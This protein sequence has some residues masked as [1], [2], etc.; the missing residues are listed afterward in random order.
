VLQRLYR[1]WALSSRFDIGYM[2]VL[3]AAEIALGVLIIRKVAYTEIDW[4]AYMQEV[5]GYLGGERDYLKLRG[6]TGALR[7]SLHYLFPPAILT[8]MCCILVKYK[9]PLVYPA[10]FLYLFSLLR[11]WTEQGANIRTAQHIFLAMYVLTQGA[12]LLLYQTRI[13]S[14]RNNEGSVRMAEA[15]RIRHVWSWRV[16][17]AALCLSKR[18]HSIFLLRLFNDGPTMLLLYVSV[19]LFARNQWFAGCVLY[20]LAVSV[21]M[22]VLLFAPGL[23]LLLLQSSP[24]VWTLIW[25]LGAG[26]ALPQLV[27][28]A[29]FLLAHPVSY[30]RK[31]FELDR[32]FFY[33]WTVNWKVRTCKNASVCAFDQSHL[34]NHTLFGIPIRSFSPRTCSRPR[35][36]RSCF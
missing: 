30:L 29:P 16:A 33:Q 5:E 32:V 35:S 15:S 36:C 9:G 12:V 31:A 6:D 2:A 11:R 19:I 24:N 34:D 23:L 18:M 13:R 27:L 4:V 25:R 7:G 20:S 8:R 28:G 22:N 26:C 14:I 21:K 1:Q 17:M 10:G 3:L